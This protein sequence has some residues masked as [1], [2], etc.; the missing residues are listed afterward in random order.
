MEEDT[1]MQEVVDVG[2][3]E[4]G[5]KCEISVHALTVIPGFHTMRVVGYNDKRPLNILIDPGSTHNFIDEE[6]VKQ[7]GLKVQAVRP[8]SVN[9]ADESDTQTDEM[10]HQLS[11]MIQGDTFVDNFLLLPLRSCDLILG[12]LVHPWET[13]NLTSRN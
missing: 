1:E 3:E 4:Q 6:L 10:C 8:Q 7:L 5:G 12:V 13:F 11:W 9:V 2:E